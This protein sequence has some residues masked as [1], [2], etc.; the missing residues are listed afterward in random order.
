MSH[1][2]WHVVHVISSAIFSLQEKG[3]DFLSQL[4]L[5][6]C[7]HIGFSEIPKTSSTGSESSDEILAEY[8]K[9]MEENRS[10]VLDNR[11]LQAENESLVNVDSKLKSE[12]ENLS[13]SL[14]KLTEDST[15]LITSNKELTLTN[16]QGQET[17]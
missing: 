5:T 2:T 17:V 3:P 10:L 11:E 7:F 15:E 12:I 1:V 9:V 14:Q 8:E 16:A 4:V 6:N 13:L